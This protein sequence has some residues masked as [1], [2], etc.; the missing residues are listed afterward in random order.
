VAPESFTAI[1]SYIV[2]V[3]GSD[4]A[5]SALSVVCDVAH[6]AKARVHVLYVIEV[7]RSLPLDAD[8][9]AESQRGESILD[10]AEKIGLSFKVQVQA[11]L[12]Q[13]RQAAHA[14]VD[15][16]IERNVDA[17]VVGVDYHRPRGKFELGRLPQYVLEHSPTQVWLIR[18]PLPDGLITTRPGTVWSR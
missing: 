6:R 9:A 10:K 2:P 12:L 16:A 1:K 4:A 17:I 15:E 11:E 3:D 5:F 8:L 18:Y 14:V 7:P 13:A